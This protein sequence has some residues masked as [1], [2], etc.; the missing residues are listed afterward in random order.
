MDREENDC[1]L[2]IIGF[3][4]S[5]VAES[6]SSAK[7]AKLTSVYSQNTTCPHCNKPLS[8][9]TY[10]RHK[11]LFCK[12]DGTWIIASSV[13]KEDQYMPGSDI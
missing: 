2:P 8:Q 7:K 3:I 4:A 1:E 10:R 13:N 5:R 9:K 12:N 11:K 6:E